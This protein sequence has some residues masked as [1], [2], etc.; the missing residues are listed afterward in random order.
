MEK[1][2]LRFLWWFGKAKSYDFAVALISHYC[3]YSG[4]LGGEFL[5]LFS[6]WVNLFK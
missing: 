2:V 4:F 6:F 3:F 5:Q 1:L